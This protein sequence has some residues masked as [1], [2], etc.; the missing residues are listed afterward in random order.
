MASHLQSNEVVLL[1][2]LM[3]QINVHFLK[4]VEYAW[5]DTSYEINPKFIIYKTTIV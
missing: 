2:S 3:N 5:T 1:I 4:S